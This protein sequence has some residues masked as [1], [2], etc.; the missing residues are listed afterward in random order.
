MPLNSVSIV[1]S[2]ARVLAAAFAEL[3]GRETGRSPSHGIKLT[4]SRGLAAAIHLLGYQQPAVDN[5]F[6]SLPARW[7]HRGAS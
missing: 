7:R 6:L 2:T 5:E 1:S 3:A 4:G